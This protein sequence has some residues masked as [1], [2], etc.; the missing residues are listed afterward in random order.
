MPIDYGTNNV[1]TSGT[2]TATSGT[3]SQ[4]LDSPLSYV[5]ASSVVSGTVSDWNPGS[6]ADVIRA[7]GTSSARINGLINTYGIDAILLYN[8]GTTGTITL[9]HAS[10]TTN[11]QF[12]IS[13]EGDYILSANGGSALIVRDKTDNKW[14]VS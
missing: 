12:L 13:W 2:F 9:T 10:G 1:I 7:S 4:R 11:N 5:T 3:F 6:S 14:R 8:V